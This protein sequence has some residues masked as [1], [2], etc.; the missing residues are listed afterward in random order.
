MQIKLERV[1][2]ELKKKNNFGSS[3]GFAST[4][5]ETEGSGVLSPTG[6]YGYPVAKL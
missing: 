3:T 1:H 4:L 2:R 5:R 6:M